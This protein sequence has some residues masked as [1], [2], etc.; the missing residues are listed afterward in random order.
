MGHEPSDMVAQ[1]LVSVII[2]VYNGEKYLARCLESVVSQKYV[3]IEILVV[4]DGSTDGTRDII[5][6]YSDADQRIICIDQTNQGLVGARRT[7][8]SVARGKYI[9]YLDADDVFHNSDVISVL[10][11]KAENSGADMVISSFVIIE[12]DIR[13]TVGICN[14][15][16]VSGIEFLKLILLE[17]G[18]WNVWSK[19]HRR[20]LYSDDIESIDIAFG[21]DVVLSTQLLLKSGCIV[22]SHEPVVDYYIYPSSMSHVM[23]DRAYKDFDAYVAWFE[24]Y[25]KRKKLDKE[26]DKELSQFNI[27]NTM[28]R[29]YWKKSHDAYREM[30]RVLY[31]LKQYPQY[32]ALI[33]QNPFIDFKYHDWYDKLGYDELSGL[34]FREDD[35]EKAYDDLC[36]WEP[37]REAC[38]Q[39]FQA[40]TL[41]SKQDTKIM[42]QQIYDRLGLVGK[43]AK[44]SDLQQYLSVVEKQRMNGEGKRTYFIE[45]QNI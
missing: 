8:I 39:T 23:D 43:T 17:K 35:V 3:N 4:N 12:G 45:I 20:D 40:G 41:Y 22:V 24:E 1:P 38:R 15:D 37:I 29:I 44:A 33:L 32:E 19:F 18:H 21:E 14:M 28:L 6:A 25:I 5:K 9:Q 26:L 34:G 11:A 16:T 2:P 42:L 30:P 36:A 13:N 31:A 7:G 10:V 27:R